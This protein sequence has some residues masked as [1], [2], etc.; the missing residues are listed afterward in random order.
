VLL[1]SETG[2]VHK[3]H[4]DQTALYYGYY[5]AIRHK[6]RSLRWPCNKPRME[7]KKLVQSYDQKISRKET[8]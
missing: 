7:Q 3:V 5:T 8:T 2:Y 1:F 6:E 4:R